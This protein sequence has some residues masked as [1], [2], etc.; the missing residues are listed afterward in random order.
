MIHGALEV[1][2]LPKK[3]LLLF[4]MGFCALQFDAREAGSCSVPVFRYALERWRPDAYKAI[5]I[6]RDSLTTRDGALLQQLKEASSDSDVPLNL[7]IR[8]VEIGAFSE[9]RLQ[10]LLKGPI[11]KQLPALAIWYPEQMGKTAP[12]WVIELTAANVKGL[13]G[14][15]KRTELVEDLIRGESVVWVFVPSGNSIKDDRAKALIRTELDVALKSL[16]K[17]SFFTT[18][19]AKEKKLTY[20]FP[21]LTLLRSDPE[22]RFLLDMLMRSESDLYEHTNEPMVFPVFGRGRTLGCLFGEYI[23]RDKIQDAVAFLAASCSCEVKALNPGLDL[24]LPAQWDRV[25]M[26][27]LYADDDDALP[28]L[29]G[30]MPEKPA[31]DK[32]EVSAALREPERKRSVLAFSGIAL[33]SVL[34]VVVFAG[35]ILNHRRKKD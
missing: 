29:T 9:A 30:V 33:S 18:A 7:L 11:P 8:E 25:L 5:C 6:Y 22:E 10:G 15:P 3:Y 13:M 35:L 14:S 1:G 24:L 20:G 21:I 27:E 12:Q 19:G 28:E 2:R 32:T 4:V 23:S 17:M 31:P 16:A 34:V 26:G